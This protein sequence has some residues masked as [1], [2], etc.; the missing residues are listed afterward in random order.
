[1]KMKRIASLACAVFFFAITA[2]IIGEGV[3]STGMP[4]ASNT[5]API[6]SPT[7]SLPDGM[8]RPLPANS[9]GA[10]KQAAPSP[11]RDSAQPTQAP[12]L[13]R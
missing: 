4:F 8:P 9:K 7:L 3:V 10:V 2:E 11:S 1:M 13:D 6:S 12:R 5:T